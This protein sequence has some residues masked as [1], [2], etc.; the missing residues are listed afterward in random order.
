MK[1]FILNF[2]EFYGSKIS[3]FAWHKRWNKSNRK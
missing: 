1:D 2:L 3:N